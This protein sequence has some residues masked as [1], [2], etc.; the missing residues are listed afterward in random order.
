MSVRFSDTD[1]DKV[2]RDEQT[3][4]LE[5]GLCLALPKRMPPPIRSAARPR[6]STPD[7]GRSRRARERSD[8]RPSR[9]RYEGTNTTAP[10]RS[11]YAGLAGHHAHL[12][13]H[14][15]RIIGSIATVRASTTLDEIR[16]EIASHPLA[17]RAYAQIQAHGTEVVFDFTSRPRSVLG[18]A[19]WHANRIIVYVAKHPS[20]KSAVGTFVHE[21]SHIQRFSRGHINDLEDEIRAHAREFLYIHGRRPRAWDRRLI[22]SYVKRHYP[23]L[24]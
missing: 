23:H 17:R 14:R 4:A 19:D 1:S 2:G 18:E 21:S 22:T 3:L 11:R 20:A 7:P 24:E 8:L 16:E 13:A 5:P 10:G 9:D 15:L 6:L 12:P